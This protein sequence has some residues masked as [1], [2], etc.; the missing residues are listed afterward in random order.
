MDSE[1]AR[2][3]EPFVF[4]TATRI[5]GLPDPRAIFN[6]GDWLVSL[7]LWSRLVEIDATGQ[8]APYLAS[9]WKK[10]LDGLTWTFEIPQ[11][12]KWSD[13]SRMT[14]EEIRDSLKKSAAGTTHLALGNLIQEISIG[15]GGSIVFKLKKQPF[16]FLTALSFVDFSITAEKSSPGKFSGPYRMVREEAGRILLEKNPHWIHREKFRP[17]SPLLFQGGLSTKAM[18][19]SIERDRGRIAYFIGDTHSAPA[20]SKDPGVVHLRTP[21]EWT[22]ALRVGKTGF[23]KM[24]ALY[25]RWLLRS[26][27]EGFNP[28]EPL[29][30]ESPVGARHPLRF[31][32]LGAADWLKHLRLAPDKK[33]AIG[34]GTL[35]ILVASQVVETPSV[36]QVLSRL[37]FLNVKTKITE[38]D[39]SKPDSDPLRRGRSGDY[40]LLFFYEG[41]SDPDPDTMWRYL[42]MAHYGPSPL[43]NASELDAASVESDSEKRAELYRSFE[44]RNLDDPFLIP[45]RIMGSRVQVKPPLIP[46]EESQFEWGMKVWTFSVA[47]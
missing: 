13:G 32:A 36:K 26:L 18:L 47:E 28:T 37:D 5:R 19:E 12:L 43:V 39:L 41:V 40:D 15:P 3:P 7:H 38:M 21:P 35:E 16:N 6:D 11:D 34:G 33:P 1:A 14:T 45:L 46:P 42:M 8:E 44:R 24:P 22:A 30:V 31:G 9:S 25:R 2:A 29:R 27:W 17:P 10:S 23:S 20:K 4:M